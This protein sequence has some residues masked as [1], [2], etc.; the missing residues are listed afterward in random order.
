MT[1]TG[2]LDELT[3]SFVRGY[4]KHGD[5]LLL[6]KAT[7]VANVRVFSFWTSPQIIFRISNILRNHWKYEK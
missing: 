7:G 6:K 2:A 4:V 1:M 5:N 3:K